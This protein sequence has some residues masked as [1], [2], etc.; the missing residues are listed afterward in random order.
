MH[1]GRTA[2][3]GEEGEESKRGSEFKLVHLSFQVPYTY[4]RLSETQGK[5]VENTKTTFTPILHPQPSALQT[6]RTTL[7]D[8]LKYT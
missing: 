3:N 6:R 7:I 8:R 5:A 4:T 2:V 1:R